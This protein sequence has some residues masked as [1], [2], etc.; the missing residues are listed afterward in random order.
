MKI[1]HLGFCRNKSFFYQKVIFL[2]EIHAIA[3]RLLD[4]RLVLKISLDQSEYDIGKKDQIFFAYLYIH[5]TE[6]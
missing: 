3:G 4:N 6:Y 1:L 2:K 5:S